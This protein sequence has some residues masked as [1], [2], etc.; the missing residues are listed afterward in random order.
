MHR[1]PLDNHH[2]ARCHRPFTRDDRGFYVGLGRSIHYG[3][4]CCP[5]TRAILDRFAGVA[6]DPKFTPSDTDDIVAAVR[7]VCRGLFG[8]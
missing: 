3:A 4:A 8:G 1:G 7:K 6:L 5:Q 2:C